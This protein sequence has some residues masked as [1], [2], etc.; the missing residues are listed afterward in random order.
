MNTI[1]MLVTKHA[2]KQPCGLFKIIFLQNVK[3][4][5][6]K[7]NFSYNNTISNAN[8]LKGKTLLMPSLGDYASRLLEANL[9]RHGINA[10]TLFDTE[11][12]IKRSLVSNTGQCLPMNIILQNAYDYI[13]E[14]QLDP[15]NTVL[16]MMES[17]VSCNLGMFI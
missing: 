3:S 16:W 2:L 8:E 11:D 6:E 10:H 13:E 14:H 9:R 5:K 4:T 1:Q 12:S 17:P 7:V 15:A